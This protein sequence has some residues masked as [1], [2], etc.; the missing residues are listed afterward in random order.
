MTFD[1]T[2]LMAM[3]RLARR[4][5]AA[6]EQALGLRAAGSPQA[7]RLSLKRLACRGLVERPLNGPP[8]L[9]MEGLAVAV[10]MLPGVHGADALTVEPASRAA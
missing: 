8:R 9:T 5:D 10:A 3:L 6:D 4:R 1:Q 2:I 7:V